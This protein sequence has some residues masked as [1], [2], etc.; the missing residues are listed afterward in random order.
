MNLE[1]VHVD[2][3]HVHPFPYHFR[4]C[5]FIISLMAERT[6]YLSRPYCYVRVCHY[7]LFLKRVHNISCLMQMM[8]G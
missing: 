7:P 4:D 1:I 5:L 8:R 6:N 2:P 3:C